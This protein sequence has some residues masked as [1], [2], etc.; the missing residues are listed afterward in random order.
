MGKWRKL[1]ETLTAKRPDL[2]VGFDPAAASDEDG[3]R[4]LLVQITEAASGRARAQMRESSGRKLRE[5]AEMVGL[6]EQLAQ[7]IS[8]NRVDEALALIS[9][10]L[11]EMANGEP[12]AEPAPL[13]ESKQDPETA[14]LRRRLD[15]SESRT[16][17]AEA[18]ADSKLPEVAKKKLRESCREKVMTPAQISARITEEQ[19]YLD[20]LTESGQVT[21]EGS[22]VQVGNEE[23]DRYRAA[24]HGMLTKKRVVEVN[25]EKIPA[26][27]GLHES[28]RVVIGKPASPTEIARDLMSGAS[29]SLPTAAIQ[30]R[31]NED[32]TD[33]L[34]EH[35]NWAARRIQESARY[36]RFQE[37]LAVSTWA[38]A[39]GDSMR[40]ALID[41]FLGSG[42]DRWKLVVSDIT[43]PQDFRTN[44]R[45]R[46]G[47]FGDLATVVEGGTYS[48][49]ATPG[50]EEETYAVAKR[51]HLFTLNMETLA[52]DD[53]GAVR[54][55]PMMLGIAAART[56]EKAVLKT[57]LSDNPTLADTV[58]LIDAAHANHQT[59]A[60]DETSLE[61]AQ[62]QFI[63]QTELSSGER[64]GNLTGK[65][66]VVPA[67]LRKVAWELVTSPRDVPAAAPRSSTVPNIFEQQ[68]GLSFF[69][70]PWQTD[71]N[72][73]QFVADPELYPTA[74]V[75]FLDGQEEPEIFLQSE[76]NV[77]SM[78]SAD[79]L[80]YKI[81]HIYGV[82]VLDHR[83]YQGSI[84]A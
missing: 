45:I 47:G 18:L 26:F 30:R 59:A 51:G 40:K 81:R 28:H 44:R 57:N 42:F 46:V 11:A 50:D 61:I 49:I 2:L 69:V 9:E 83:G 55:I 80:T 22:R 72:N 7:L 23:R 79:K 68:D 34:R 73:W 13:Q 71:T 60:L 38:E 76:E 27:R 8:E 66:L 14:D 62:Q 74:E 6:L 54:N 63:K 17:L 16:A 43:A 1:L 52:N 15:L 19:R 75:G 64:I 20:T 25:G 4:D 36:S 24:M 77:G 12:A 84:V 32:P 21:G 67:E 65:W 39:F 10:A 37:A 82:T 56:L 78:M 41:Q 33:Q 70:N 53:L 48:E 3:A 58:A 29:L 35:H 31:W 5:A